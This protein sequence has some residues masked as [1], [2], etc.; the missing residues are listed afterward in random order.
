[1]NYGQLQ[2][3][4]SAL[5]GLLTKWGIRK[6]DRV[7]LLLNSSEL[8]VMVVHAL[9]RLGAVTV[10]L[11][12]RQSPSELLH[13]IVDCDPTL[14]L[15][16]AVYDELRNSINEKNAAS[17][18]EILIHWKSSDELRENL[19]H[20]KPVAGGSID[21][22]LLQSIIYTS[23]STGAPKGVEITGS[24]LL[25]SAI[26]FGM[27]HGC[28]PSD[29][30]LLSMPL[31]HVGGYAILFR[32]VLHGSGIVLHPKFDAGDLS[33][34]LD[35]DEITLISL[36]PTMLESLL[37]VRL[38]SRH[39]PANLRIIFLGGSYTP[40]SLTREIIER[41]LP[42]AFTYGMTESCSQVAISS[43]HDLSDSLE[44]S[45]LGMYPTEVKIRNAQAGKVGEILLRGPTISRGYWKNR[46]ASLSALKGGWYH[47]GDMG[48][49]D[50]Q[51]GIIVLGRRA[52]MII[53]G[54]ENIYPAE[55]ESHLLEHPAVE[56][57]VAIGEED[58]KWGERVEVLVQFKEGVD[59]PSAL[60]L[61]NFLRGR[62][63]SY[64]IPKVYHFLSS[65][66]SFS[67]IQNG[68]KLKTRESIRELIEKKAETRLATDGETPIK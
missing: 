64:K 2:E 10:P 1:L 24:N 68:K 26:S 51:G 57:A 45:Y 35:Q 21:I 11:N 13:Q 50:S 59:H 8:Y 20:A 67:K 66:S 44:F 33:R 17:K 34:S 53:S 25:W 54:G 23:G 9:T 12:V 32:S 29:R 62:I 56:D 4:V 28:V 16:D 41:K 5:S 58:P 7:T 60:E 52:D 46:K 27:R 55:I 18:K 22:S 14:I 38:K 39:F 36:V 47:T 40:P 15:Y 65:S 63:G 19:I 48:Y 6:G 42:V 3:K 49:L 37:K 31:F 61:S 43:V 30:W